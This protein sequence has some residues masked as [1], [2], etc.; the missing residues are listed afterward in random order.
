MIVAAG[1]RSR[2]A[3]TT[4]VSYRP[5][6]TRSPASASTLASTNLS[7]TTARRPLTAHRTPANL[8]AAALV[9]RTPAVQHYR[10]SVALPHPRTR[11]RHS[12]ARGCGARAIYSDYAAT[13]RRAAHRRYAT[14]GSYGLIGGSGV[15]C[16]STASPTPST[17]ALLQPPPPLPASDSLPLPPEPAFTSRCQG[18]TSVLSLRRRRLL[19]AMA[20]TQCAHPTCDASDEPVGEGSGYAG[21]EADG[22]DRAFVS[23][24]GGRARAVGTLDNQYRGGGALA[25]SALR[26]GAYARDGRAR[27]ARRQRRWSIGHCP[28]RTLAPDESVSGQFGDETGASGSVSAPRGSFVSH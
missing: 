8:P 4:S 24:E 15:S 19:A 14:K 9:A 16:R 2:P 18:L 17:A 23:G 10:G 5:P 22:A 27:V 3:L 28:G 1:P 11:L 20:R 7:F 21:R 13:L 25:R 26:S 12:A 6:P